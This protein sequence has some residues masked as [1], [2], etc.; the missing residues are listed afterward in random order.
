MSYGQS[1]SSWVV[2]FLGAFL[3]SAFRNFF[4]SF[5]SLYSCHAFEMQDATR[6]KNL[7]QDKYNII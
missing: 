4:F 7:K 3:D 5:L 1:C 2:G 6:P